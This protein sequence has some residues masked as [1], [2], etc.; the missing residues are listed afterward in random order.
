ML[1]IIPVVKVR[2]SGG[3]NVN[4]PGLRR[5]YCFCESWSLTGLIS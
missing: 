1:C 5:G 4:N 3:Y 2:V